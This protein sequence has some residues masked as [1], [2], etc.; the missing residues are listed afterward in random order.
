MFHFI[1]KWKIAD[2]GRGSAV[3]C[4]AEKGGKRE[5][6]SVLFVLER[7]THKG[8]KKERAYLLDSMN[9]KH[10]MP[11]ARWYERLG[12]GC[13]RRNPFSMIVT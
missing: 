8:C 6:H 1:H 4:N 10:P 2:L 7:C 13:S 5:R 12:P 11:L 3:F 9:Q